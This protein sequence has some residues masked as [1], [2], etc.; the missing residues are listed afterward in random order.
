MSFINIPAEL[1]FVLGT[2]FP[3]EIICVKVLQCENIKSIVIKLL[4]ENE[5]ISK[6]DNDVQ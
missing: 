3:F 2:K 5:L 4:E 1:T 6:T